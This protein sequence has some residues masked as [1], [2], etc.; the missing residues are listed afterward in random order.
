MAGW[1]TWLQTCRIL[2]TTWNGPWPA[3]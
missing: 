3:N 2:P 1:S